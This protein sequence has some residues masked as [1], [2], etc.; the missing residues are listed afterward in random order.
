ML[1]KIVKPNWSYTGR[2]QKPPELTLDRHLSQWQPGARAEDQVVL[3]F[4]I[5]CLR[6]RLRFP[7]V[8]QS[9][10]HKT[11]KLDD[12]ATTLSLCIIELPAGL[13][14]LYASADTRCAPL[15]VDVAPLQR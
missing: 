9:F 8:L 7:H 10:Q 2:F 14:K 3:R 5:T 13:G 11:L 6:R 12:P 1:P 15:P 4:G